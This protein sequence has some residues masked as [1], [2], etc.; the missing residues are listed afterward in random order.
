MTFQTGSDGGE[1]T[2]RI[3]L[4]EVKPQLVNL[5]MDSLY[6]VVEYPHADVFQE[7]ASGAADLNDPELFQGKPRGDWQLF[8]R[9]P[10]RNFQYVR[11]LSVL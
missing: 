2:S 11:L 3:V 6:L 7:W 8:L 9:D 4:R 5:S 10:L 1:D